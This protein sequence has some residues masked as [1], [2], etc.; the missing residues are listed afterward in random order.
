MIKDKSV[1]E[2]L[3]VLSSKSP[4]PGGGSVAALSGALG[5]ALVSM[6]AN[7]TIGKDGYQNHRDDIK[8]I[9]YECEKLRYDYELLIEKDIDAFSNFMKATGLPNISEQQKKER[10]QKV[11]EALMK[12]AL[13]PLEIAEKSEKLMD[14]CVE[15][16]KLGNKNVISDA[17][18]GAILAEATLESAILNVK[19]NLKSIK[20][21]KQKEIINDKINKLIE[22]N[23]GKKEKVMQIIDI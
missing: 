1:K 12:A 8:K 16:S 21:T 3:E 17:G 14:I 9:L 5:A 2:F 22:K 23:A 10:K 13:V 19:I 4:T 6:V 15:I 11:Q 7:L 18:V 20:D